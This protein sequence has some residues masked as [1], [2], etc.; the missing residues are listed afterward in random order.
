MSVV[1][2]KLIFKAGAA[3]SVTDPE[4]GMRHFAALAPQH[5]T[6]ALRATSIET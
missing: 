4:P 5:L 1:R 6:P 2:V 3:I